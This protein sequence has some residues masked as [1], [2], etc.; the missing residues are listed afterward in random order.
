MGLE[1]MVKR[2]KNRMIVGM[3]DQHFPYIDEKMERITLKYFRKNK[4]KITDV[5]FMGDGVDN[6]AMSKY[7]QRP[8]DDTLLQE[9]LDLYTEHIAKYAAIVPGAN[10]YI[11]AGNHDLGRFDMVKKMN[12]SLASLRALDFKKLLKESFQNHGRKVE[13]TF[14]DPRIDTRLKGGVTGPRRNAESYPDFDCDI[15]Y[16]HQHQA[17]KVPRPKSHFAPEIKSV[18]VV[19]AMGNIGKMEE[20]Y[21]SY[22]SYQNGSVS[23]RYDDSGSKQVDL[24]EVKAGPLY[25]DGKKYE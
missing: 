22:N 17:M 14:G 8:E 11:L 21:K 7:P 9:E 4:D 1:E 20:Q 15:F 23:I 6:P 10:V 3:S 19:P 24:V 25:L 16:G 12:R 18:Y 13:F 2:F 5:V